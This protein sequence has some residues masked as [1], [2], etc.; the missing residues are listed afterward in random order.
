VTPIISDGGRFDKLGGSASNRNLLT[1]M[2][3][4]PT[5]RESSSWSYSELKRKVREAAL[6]H[7]MY[8]RG[9][10]AD[11]SEFPLEI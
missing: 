8:I 9:S 6:S 11:V 5:R 3:I 4:G 1:P 2:G 7:E 10:R